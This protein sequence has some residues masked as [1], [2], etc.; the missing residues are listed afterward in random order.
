M[1]KT[2][3]SSGS[4]NL[5]ASIAMLLISAIAV[6]LRL[7]FRISARQNLTVSD[8]LIVLSLLFMVVYCASIIHYVTAGPGP[9]TFDVGQIK[10]NVKNGGLRWGIAMAKTLYLCDI[11]F[12]ATVSTAKLSILA[13]YRS[14]FG[15][16]VTFR[17]VNYAMVAFVCLFWIV[18]TFLYIFQCS[19]VHMVWDALASPVYCMSSGKLTLAF[20][21]TNLFVDVTMVAMPPFMIGQLNLRSAQ[22]YSVIGILLLGGVV[23]IVSMVRLAYIWVPSNPDFMNTAPAMVASSVQLG[24]AI[25]CACFPT[26]AP[27]LRFCSGA[28]KADYNNTPGKYYNYGSGVQNNRPKPVMNSRHT[29]TESEYE[30]NTASEYERA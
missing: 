30:L 13:L 17:R 9:G 1:N 21:L 25:L 4:E 5:G 24:I 11:F 3:S 16:S 20:E 26:Y 18:F 23:C 19:P 12:I 22:K 7:S 28:R 6:I 8:G 15:V 27:L 29:A 2:L 10:A 14:I